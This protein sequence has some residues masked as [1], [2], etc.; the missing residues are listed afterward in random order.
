MREDAESARI[1]AK[2]LDP[3]GRLVIL[4]ER[5]W[6]HIAGEH[7]E[8]ARFERAIMETVTH[9]THRQDEVRASRERFFAARRGPSRWLRVVV[10]FSAAPAFVVTAFGQ[11]DEP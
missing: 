2:A 11:D 3:N 7:P 5:Q 1:R 6:L 9:P 10:D 4:H 8:M